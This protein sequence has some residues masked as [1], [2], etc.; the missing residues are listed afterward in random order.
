MS[1]DFTT[2]EYAAI[3]VPGAALLLGTILMFPETWSTL[4]KRFTNLGGFGLLVVS[5]FIVGQVLHEGGG[6]LTDHLR[7]E[8]FGELPTQKLLDDTQTILSE[9]QKANLHRQVRQRFGF[10]VIRERA[11]WNVEADATGP[12]PGRDELVRQRKAEWFLIGREIYILVRNAGRTQRIDTFLRDYSL[13]RGLAF[14]ALVLAGIAFYRAGTIGTRRKRRN[15]LVVALL[16]LGAAGLL[17]QRMED[18]GRYYARELFLTYIN[19]PPA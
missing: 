7:R 12:S 2:Y 5:A 9:T 10:I 6:L 1:P 17:Y 14:V 13:T 3:V 18:S 19:L 16:L 8:F 4:E 15:F 11:W